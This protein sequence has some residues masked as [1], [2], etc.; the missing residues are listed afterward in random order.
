MMRKTL[1][2]LAALGIAWGATARQTLEE[3]TDSIRQ[4]YARAQAG[5]PADQNEVG[6]WYYRGRHVPQNFQTA[7]Q[8]WAKAAQ[9][10]NALAIGNLAL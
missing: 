8:Y 3:A 9:S 5:N 6:G 1:L 7:A 4:I 10:G 2:L